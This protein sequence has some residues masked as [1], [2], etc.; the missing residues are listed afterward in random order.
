M[1]L[2]SRYIPSPFDTPPSSDMIPANT[3]QN[4]QTI[5]DKIDW[6]DYMIISPFTALAL[7]YVYVSVQILF[8]QK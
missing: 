1:Q 4:T 5:E 7:L 2:R 8:F 3:P 6:T